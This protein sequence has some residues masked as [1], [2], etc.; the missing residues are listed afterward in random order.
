MILDDILGAGLA[1]PCQVVN[2]TLAINKGEKHIL[3]LLNTVIRTQKGTMY[4]N[5]NL[6]W[7][8]D[9]LLFEQND[10]ILVA[11]TEDGITEAINEQLPQVSVKSVIAMP[12]GSELNVN[13]ACVINSTGQYISTVIPF[14]RQR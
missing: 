5:R 3:D 12:N 1:F 4:Y 7:R 9:E 10:T 8:R 2:G 6:G 13:V 14:N 11:L